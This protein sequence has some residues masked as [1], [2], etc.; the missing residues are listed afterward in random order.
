M[1]SE[2]GEI[3]KDIEIL[4]L[5]VYSGLRDR[6]GNIDTSGGCAQR[7]DRQRMR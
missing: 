6:E 1:C 2:R 3:E 5:G 7:D 4:L